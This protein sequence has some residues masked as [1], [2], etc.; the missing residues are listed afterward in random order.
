M[1]RFMR[2]PRKSRRILDSFINDE[3]ISGYAAKMES[4]S[5]L[6]FDFEGRT[7]LEVGSGPGLLSDFFLRRGSRLTIT[8]GRKELLEIADEMYKE[9][10]TLESIKQI[11]LEDLTNV[12]IKL[13]GVKYD[14]VFAFGIL[15][16]LSNPKQVIGEL[17]NHC[18]NMFLMETIVNSYADVGETVVE[19]SDYNQ[20]LKLGSRLS[21]MEYVNTLKLY[22]E[23]V[24]F[25][26]QPVH[27]D[28]SNFS[29]G[30]YPAR[31]FLVGSRDKIQGLN[32][33]EENT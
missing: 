17:A 12:R 3:A 33:F 15:Y 10:S 29:A 7:I 19:R 26:I 24:Y 18:S 11:D 9:R 20:A 22:F 31:I 27:P 13:K 2:L 4:L 21:V 1:F 28:Y 6:P 16:H 5:K 23:Y 8:D 25:P 14:I 32:A 30:T